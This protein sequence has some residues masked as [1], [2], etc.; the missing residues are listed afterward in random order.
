MLVIIAKELS[1]K[2]NG[3]LST[4]LYK[5]SPNIFIGNVSGKVRQ[6]IIENIIIKNSIMA[7]VIYDYPNEQGFIVEEFNNCNIFSTLNHIK[8]VKK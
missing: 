6:K 2:D 3:Q 5:V 7:C 1:K 8:L 4:L